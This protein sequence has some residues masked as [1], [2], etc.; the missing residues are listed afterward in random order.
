[1]RIDLVEG[2]TPRHFLLTHC[3]DSGFT[4]IGLLIF[5]ALM[6]IALAGTGLVWHAESRRLKEGE[7]L[8]AGEQYRRAIGMYYERSPGEKKFP[9]TIDELLH[10]RRYPNVQRHL[11]RA[12]VDPITAS[13]DWGV[14][15][16]PAGGIAGVYSLSEDKPVKQANFRQGQADFEGRQKYSEWR[17]VYVPQEVAG[18][19][20]ARKD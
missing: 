2:L 6:G 7:L 5:I 4:Y 19:A 14:V 12:Y 11:R 20:T 10:D 16:G 8:F 13:K 3:R 17:F 9:K 15:E 18:G 1:M